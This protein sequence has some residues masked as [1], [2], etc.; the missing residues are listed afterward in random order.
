MLQ[1]KL[2]AQGYRFE[3]VNAGVSGDTSAGGLRRLDWALQGNVRVLVVAL[4]G[5]DGLRGLPVQEMKQN[6][7]T[8][9]S[10]ARQRN[11]VV[12]LAGMEAPPNYGQEYSTAFRQVFRDIA[13]QERGAPMLSGL[14]IWGGGTLPPEPSATLPA[15]RS[16]DAFLRGLWTMGGGEAESVPPSFQALDLA[17]DVAMIVAVS[18]AQSPTKSAAQ[19]LSDLE[20]DWFQPALAAVRG[21]RVGRLQLHLNDRLVSLTRWNS[22][23]WWRRR[24]APC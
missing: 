9:I 14:W 8:I 17:R 10:E 22:W 4:G 19:A 2:D 12:I 23:R 15:L 1:N 5:N 13:R 20:R 11:V 7:A 21:G 24:R 18:A 3:I 6:I 16:D